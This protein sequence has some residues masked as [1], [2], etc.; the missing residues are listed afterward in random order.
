MDTKMTQDTDTAEAL[1]AP[2]D[3]DW[4]GCCCVASMA[5]ETGVVPVLAATLLAADDLIRSLAAKVREIDGAV[6][7]ERAAC[8]QLADEYATW[9]GSNFAEWFNKLAAAI[10][11]RAAPASQQKDQT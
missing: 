9:G 6:D 4:Y 8:A 11:A 3:E 5:P 2:H 7:A 1:A 10:R